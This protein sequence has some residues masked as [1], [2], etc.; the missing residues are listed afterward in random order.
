MDLQ[1]VPIESLVD[2][3]L[4]ALRK[5]NVSAIVVYAFA[6]HGT[7]PVMRVVHN[8]TEIGIAAALNVLSSVNERT[9]EAAGRAIHEAKQCFVCHSA[10][11]VAVRWLELSED[12]R[13]RHRDVA[14]IALKAAREAS[15]AR[16]LGQAEA[17]RD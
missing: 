17:V 9:I 5:K 12:T 6:K 15:Q 13:A 2:G 10:E 8:T 11:D 4:K 7:T 1:E 16:V 14:H 3:A